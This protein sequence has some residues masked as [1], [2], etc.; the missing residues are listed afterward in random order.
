MAES[1]QTPNAP[2]AKSNE[3]PAAEDLLKTGIEAVNL[4]RLRIGLAMVGTLGLFYFLVFLFSPPSEEIN[5]PMLVLDIFWLIAAPLLLFAAWRLRKKPGFEKVKQILLLGGLG[6][7]MA[8]CGAVSG[9]DEAGGRGLTTLVIGAFGAASAFILPIGVMAPLLGLGMAAYFITLQLDTGQPFAGLAKDITPVS[10]LVLAAII[11]H[12]LY[13]ARSQS[14]ANR[15]G[16]ERARDE[17]EERVEERSRHLTE[18][19]QRLAESESLYR[20]LAN[21]IYDVIFLTGPGLIPSYYSPSV[22]RFLGYSAKEMLGLPPEK[23]IFPESLDLVRERSRDRLEAE[24]RGMGDD[25]NR[26]WSLQMFRK[27]GKRI[28]VEVV[29]SVLREK[30]GSFKGLLG[31]M[32]EITARKEAEEALE[33]HNRLVNT[34]MDNLQVGVFMVDAASGETLLAN[35]RAR[36]LLGRG[37]L[38]EAQKEKLAELYQAYKTGS[39]GLYP[40]GEL[41]LIRGLKGESSTVDDMYVLKPDGT[42]VFL[43]VFGTPVKDKEGKV[44][45]SLVSFSDITARKRAEQE[46]HKMEAQLLQAQKMDALGTLAGGIAHDFNNILAAIMGYSE[47]AQEDLPGGHPVGQDLAEITN[48][49]AKAKELIRHI[50]TFSRKWESDR[51]SISLNQ[52]VNATAS[53]LERAQSKMLSLRLDLDEELGQVKADA[54]QLEQ[55]IFNLAINAADS[56]NGEGQ[57]SIITRN[58][59]VSRRVCD[60]SGQEFSGDFAVLSVIDRGAGI[61]GDIVGKIFDPFFTTKE[62]GKGTGLGLS[63]VFGTVSSHGGYIKVASRDGQGTRFDIYL[64]VITEVANG[65]PRVESETGMPPSGRG[66]LLVVD[67]EPSVRAVACRTLLRNG[68]QVL[69]ACSGEQALALYREQM[70]LINGVVLDLGMPGMGGRKCLM[71]MREF[72]P[73]VKVL[74]ASGYIQHEMGNEWEELGAAGMIAKPYRKADLLNGVRDMLIDKPFHPDG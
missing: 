25:E 30:D 11:S 36:E 4:D 67:D 53:L 50:L 35:R 60:A 32:R 16:L 3:T 44:I 66:T 47:L 24:Q 48:A 14:L 46:R 59:R 5:R 61:P 57:V 28:W 39:G 40:T 12:V 56:M 8:W 29:T 55:V 13:R 6:V 71:K 65:S 45:A 2:P 37:I 49:A 52:V 31:V 27:D 22:E 20:L 1:D 73:G 38:P 9:L 15:I 18:A 21:N 34:L 19:N 72:D 58:Q 63:T 51:K 54:H 64:P 42:K 10:L 41:P 69:Q 7:I 23:Y 33:E 74:I 68:Y 43:E 26:T 17:L 62:V 70:G